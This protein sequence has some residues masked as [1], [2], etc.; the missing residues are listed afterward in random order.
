MKE[1]RKREEEGKRKKKAEAR[2][3]WN[4]NNDI[5]SYGTMAMTYHGHP[6]PAEY[7]TRME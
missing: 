4:N 7:L 6:S 2:A 1:E 5:R 3:T